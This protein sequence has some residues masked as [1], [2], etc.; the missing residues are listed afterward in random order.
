MNRHD[1][2]VK[3]SL[4]G[5]RVRHRKAIGTQK[6]KER[7]EVSRW[8]FHLTHPGKTRIRVRKNAIP[9]QRRCKE[10]INEILEEEL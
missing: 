3:C 2:L 7:Q 6:E 4:Y 9:N 5:A 8:Y 10:I 1:L